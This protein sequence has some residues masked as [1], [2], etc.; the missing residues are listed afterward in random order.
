MSSFGLKRRI[1]LDAAVR[2]RLRTATQTIPAGMAPGSVNIAV[3]LMSEKN[4]G[5]MSDG[6]DRLS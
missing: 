3:H 2:L 1:R 5:V 6:P 4:N